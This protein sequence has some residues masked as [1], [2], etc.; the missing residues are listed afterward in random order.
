[1]RARTTLIRTVMMGADYYEPKRPRGRPGL[2]VGTD[3]RIEG[4]IID[5]NAR[6]GDRVVIANKKRIKH[7]DAAGY[8]IRE[9][10]VVVEKDAVIPSG[11]VI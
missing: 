5:K 11:T 9:G 3:C 1:V 7:L 6:I 2:G 10:I 8:C 4:A